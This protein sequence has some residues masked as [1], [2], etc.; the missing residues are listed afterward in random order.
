LGERRGADGI[1]VDTRLSLDGCPDAV[2]AFLERDER[3]DGPTPFARDAEAV[4]GRRV[5]DLGVRPEMEARRRDER[6]ELD[7][8]LAVQRE[9]PRHLA[10]ATEVLVEDSAERNE[11]VEARAE[12]RRAVDGAE[13][14]AAKIE[15]NIVDRRTVGPN[16]CRG[17]AAEERV[18][19]VVRIAA[20][21]DPR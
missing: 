15:P 14:D 16:R 10:V 21:L 11:D 2:A 3:T 7:R 8:V 4:V 13:N 12:R 6:D 9:H 5:V 1:V 20:R 19:R 17:R 18:D